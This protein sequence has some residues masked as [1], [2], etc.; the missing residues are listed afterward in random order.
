MSLIKIY[1][2]KNCDTMKKALK[3]LDAKGVP[4]DFHNYKK[5]GLDEDVLKLAI[6]QHGW[7]IVINKRGTSWRGL[8]EDVKQKADQDSV[9]ALAKEN[10]S[11]VKRPLLMIGDTTYL[12]FSEEDYG[13]L[14]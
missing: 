2:I 1:G 10:P 13:T 9:V 5:D 7:D 8:P 4:Y 11:L 14:F 12:G 6:E 3:Y